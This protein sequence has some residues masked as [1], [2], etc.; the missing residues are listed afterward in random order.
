MKTIKQIITI[1][2]LAMFMLN[3]TSGNAQSSSSENELLKH[4]FDLSNLNYKETS[5]D[6]TKLICYTVSCCSIGIF[7]VE[8]WSETTCYYYSSSKSS[9][10][11]LKTT[12]FFKKNRPKSGF[13][14]VKDDVIIA[15]LKDSLGNLLVLPKGKYKLD[16]KN[17]ITYTPSILPIDTSKKMKKRCIDK[18]VDGTIFGHHYHHEVHV[19][20]SFSISFSKNTNIYTPQYIDLNLND[21][22]IEKVKNGDNS[23]ILNNDLTIE[24]QGH[25]TTLK[26]GEYQIAEDGKIYFYN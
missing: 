10:P 26:A 3:P 12:L 22:Q 8:V 9:K 16:N 24:N 1:V 18:V 7:T 14:E 20:F 2:A 21:K 4:D 13:V 11:T 5:E 6:K 17:S 19:C 23:F 25:K 15:G